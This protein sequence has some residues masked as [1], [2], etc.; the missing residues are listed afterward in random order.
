MLK[1]FRA[2]TRRCGD[3]RWHILGRAQRIGIGRC[4]A[5]TEIGAV[6]A[7]AN[8]TRH[9]RLFDCLAYHYAVFFE[10]LR[11]DGVQKRITARIQRQH[12]HGEHFGLFERYQVHAEHGGQ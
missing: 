10:L 8:A 4:L 2:C 9:T 5:I 12:K 11:H 6:T 3:D 7:T 1:Q